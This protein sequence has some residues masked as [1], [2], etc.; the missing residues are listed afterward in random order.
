MHRRDVIVTGV[1]VFVFLVALTVTRTVRVRRTQH[2]GTEIT[3]DETGKESISVSCASE[4]LGLALPEYAECWVSKGSM[5]CEYSGY[6][7]TQTV[8]SLDCDGRRLNNLL[9]K[10]VL[11][12]RGGFLLSHTTNRQSKSTMKFH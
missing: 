5:R 8:G 12:R 9:T 4:I 10:D 3:W 6:T 11:R 2:R 1:V 7:V